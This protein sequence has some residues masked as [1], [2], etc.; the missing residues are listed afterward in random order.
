MSVNPSTSPGAEVALVAMP[1]GG[2][3][4][5]SLALSLLSAELQQVQVSC[6]VHYLNLDFAER[7]GIEQYDRYAENAEGVFLG[8]W[9]FSD[10][11]FPRP[12]E[13]GERFVEEVLI[14]L[15]RF[16]LEEIERFESERVLAQQFL[17]DCLRARDWSRYRIIGF[18][19]TFAQNTPSLAFA[20]MIKQVSPASVIVFGGANCEGE[21]GVQLGRSFPWIDFVCTGEG[22]DVFPELARQVL[23]R[24]PQAPLPG[25]AGARHDPPLPAR[26][27]TDLDRL[28]Y[29][30]VSAYF[31]RAE[32]SSLRA[33]LRPGIPME[34]SRGCWW[35]EKHHCTFCGLNGLTMR[36]RSKS[37]GRALAEMRELT[38][39][40][41]DRVDPNR[42]LFL[43]DNI[44]DMKYFTTLV[45]AL[46]DSGLGISVF[47]ETKA[48]LTKDQVRMLAD[49][50]I[51]DVQ[52]GIESLHSSLLR[53]M[54]KGCTALQNLQLLKW[55]RELG[56][57]PGYNLLFG[58]PN[59]DPRWYL[60]QVETIR[61]IPHLTPPRYV[62]PIRLDRFSPYFDEPHLHGISN[63]RPVRALSYIYP[64]PAEE[65]ARIAY[66]FDFEFDDGRNPATYVGPLLDAVREWMALSMEP[67][68]FGFRW[69]ARLILWDARRRDPGDLHIL[70]GGRDRLY[71]F[72]DK[73]RGRA[74]AIAYAQSECGLT[75]HEATRLLGEWTD[76]GL[77][78]EDE[79]CVLALAVL[80]TDAVESSVDLQTPAV[81]S[82]GARNGVATARM[83]QRHPQHHQHAKTGELEG[84]TVVLDRA[85]GRVLILDPLASQVWKLSDG[86]R[87][88]DAIAAEL[89]G[90]ESSL[91][92][93]RLLDA[94][95]VI[96]HLER[97]ALLDLGDLHR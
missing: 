28:P 65:L 32:R 3:H 55:C 82:V 81:H 56:I 33:E 67:F 95:H 13:A 49:A 26:M 27:V 63:I 46:R 69:G 87:T 7:I 92:P 58:F 36:F 23:G 40:Y 60:E 89:A 78:I 2:I 9:L 12:E 37:S 77:L 80:A 5:P 71:E 16:T 38:G 70:D 21:M 42:A 35:G 91:R 39:R 44:L 73:T 66:H 62:C 88:A 61:R 10:C 52:P 22:D 86:R 72:C 76:A 4:G 48:N 50:G 79:G 29:P 97:E 34:T 47:Y 17:A 30:D 18:T 54:R 1:F 57:R 90:P 59:E 94:E 31:D 83:S 51:R 8:E 64:L 96:E 85:R 14:P 53:L 41:K 68:F 6:D 84:R 19:T 11:L 25:L 75:E 15:E 43:T 45:P 20:R 24:S 74:E 93:G